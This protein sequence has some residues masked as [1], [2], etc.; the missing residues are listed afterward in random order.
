[1]K[2]ERKER[3][4]NKKEKSEVK[5]EGKERV[6]SKKNEQKEKYYCIVGFT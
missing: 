4:S 2:V 1:M 6:T 3:A 5:I